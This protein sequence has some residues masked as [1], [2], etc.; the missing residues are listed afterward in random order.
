MIIYLHGLNSSP[1]SGKAVVLAEYC[2]KHNIAC[3]V[4]QLHHRPR[5]A[6][7]QIAE[8]LRTTGNHLLVGSSM[9]GY[10]ATWFCE[11]HHHV[12]AVLINPA[13]RLADKLGDLP[14]KQQ[15]NYHT[16]D[17]YVFGDEH[18]QE[19]RELATPPIVDGNKYLLLAQTGDEVLDYRE[20]VDFY[21]GAKHIIESGGNHSFQDFARFLPDIVAF[22]DA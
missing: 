18:L 5:R 11:N 10:Y 3:A 7:A 8:L 14:G 22:A 6:A 15:Q 1:L 12:R 17:S 16:G 4:P 9:G 13:V 21:A 20:A 2:A 19:F